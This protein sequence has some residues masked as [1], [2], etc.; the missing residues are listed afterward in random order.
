M[1]A[2]HKQGYFFEHFDPHNGEGRSVTPITGWTTSVVL[3]MAGQRLGH[4][5]LFFTAD[6][7]PE[8]FFA[9]IITASNITCRNH[10]VTLD[11]L[12]VKR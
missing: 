9:G 11:V 7:V 3:L 12:D 4:L 8:G 10:R 2:Y 5:L 6:P 1:E